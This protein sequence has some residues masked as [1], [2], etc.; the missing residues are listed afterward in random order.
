MHYDDTG[1]GDPIVFQPGWISTA[2]AWAGIV[3]ALQGSYRCIVLETRG[4]GESER[5]AAGHSIAQYADD[6]LALA[7]HLGLDRFT[8]VGHSMGGV[9]A[10]EAAVRAPERVERLVYVASMADASYVPGAIWEMLYAVGEAVAS[11]DQDT[12]RNFMMGITARRD[13]V[14]FDAIAEAAVACSPEFVRESIRSC[15]TYKPSTP[16]SEIDTP[17]LII[18]GSADA[19]LGASLATHAALPNAALQVFNRASHLVNVD[20]PAETAA[21]IDDFMQNGIVTAEMLMAG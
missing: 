15:A 5:T 11:G 1:S 21:A 8:V 18:G 7:D 19:F 16:V 12:A 10:T 9:I 2:A 13:G 20:V 14:P 4:T 3:P 17:A 6:L